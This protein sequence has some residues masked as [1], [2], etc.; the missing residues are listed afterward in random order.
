M[1]VRDTLYVPLRSGQSSEH[2]IIHRGLAS[3]TAVT[4]L[5]QVEDSGYS[6]VRLENDTEGWLPTQ[7]L[8]SEP[9]AADRLESVEREL[10]ELEEQYQRALLRL[11]DAE[12]AATEAAN[13][14][15]ALAANQGALQREL[16]RITLLAAET[17][18]IEQANQGLMAE[19][20]S[21]RA[22]IDALSVINQTLRGDANQIWYVAGAGTVLIGLLFGFYAARRIYQRRSIS[23]W[24]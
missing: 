2:A 18:A 8:V 14:Q 7:Y 4:L 13:E 10:L 17:I 15:A 9:I 11:Q 1:Y 3:G 6:R 12:A 5:E 24:S 20:D 16:D 23:G 22:E 21:L 19:Q